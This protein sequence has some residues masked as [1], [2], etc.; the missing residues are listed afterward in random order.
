MTIK[1]IRKKTGLSQSKFA[2]KY[3]IPVRTIQEWEQDRATPPAYFIELLEEKTADYVSH[4]RIAPKVSFGTYIDKPFANCD[5][6]YP[7]QQRKVAQLLAVLKASPSVKKVILFGSSITNH[8]HIASDVD[9]Y[10]EMDENSNP[11]TQSFDFE[12]DFWNNYTVDNR[13]RTEIES[14]G[15]VIY[16]Q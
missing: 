5:R 15:V 3:A 16:E 12:F 4:L 14:K 1:E 6:V 9:V 11:I 7:I 13:L 2:A 8:C 10:A